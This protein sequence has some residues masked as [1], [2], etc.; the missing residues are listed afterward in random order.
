[1]RSGKYLIKINV[2]STIFG[3]TAL[4]FSFTC[5]SDN[6]EMVTTSQQITVSVEPKINA[7]K[8]GFN[9]KI[10]IKKQTMDLNIQKSILKV[11]SVPETHFDE[12]LVSLLEKFKSKPDDLELI[13]ELSIHEKV[14]LQHARK[15]LEESSNESNL[16]ITIEALSLINSVD[17]IS[18]L[19]SSD[20]ERSNNIELTINLL[21]YLREMPLSESVNTY[22]DFLLKKH[23]K[24]LSL[25]QNILLSMAIYDA[26]NTAKWATYYRSP[27][28]D[29][30]VRYLGLY[31][32]SMLGKDDTLQRWILDVL[33]DKNKPPTH[34]HYY[35]L[36]ALSRQLSDEVFNDFLSRSYV[37][38]IIIDNVKLER[39]FHQGSTETRLQLAPQL[40]N[41]NYA[42]MRNTTFSFLLK[43][44]GFEK[45]W[46]QLNQQQRLSAVRLS[47]KLEV[48]IVTPNA[49]ELAANHYLWI[50]LILAV[51]LGVIVFVIFNNNN[52]KRLKLKEAK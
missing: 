41:S 50:S 17:A 39:D 22:L 5:Y 6:S 14:L 36:V 12:S 9:E 8:K 26:P 45:T 19:F 33:F 37:S 42:E 25:L 23:S 43:E 28:I 29:P 48:P 21:R 47:H 35:L 31:L 15:Q 13:K 46:E 44:Q 52:C 40:I 49:D 24:N 10:F 27:G 34:Q 16:I 18:F 4:V 51:L 2:F 20:D 3:F 32:A 1:M 38:K 11:A 30:E 7:K